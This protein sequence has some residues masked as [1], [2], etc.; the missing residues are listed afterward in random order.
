MA[1]RSEV[2][3]CFEEGEVMMVAYCVLTAL[4]TYRGFDPQYEMEVSLQTLFIDVQGSIV[5]SDVDRYREKSSR[6][7]SIRRIQGES[8]RNQKNALKQLGVVMQKLL[9]TSQPS[10][11]NFLIFVDGL[12]NGCFQH[13][14]DALQQLSLIKK[15][16]RS[17][18]ARHLPTP[19]F[20][21]PSLPSNSSHSANSHEETPEH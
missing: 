7:S 21:P 18:S 20:T 10:C 2:G 17:Q 4:Q 6:R 8:A 5:V 19:N 12:A 11:D 14:E 13:Y 15:L 1:N 9:A 16:E 3:E